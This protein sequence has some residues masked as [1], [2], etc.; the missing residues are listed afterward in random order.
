MSAKQ[1]A[2]EAYDQSKK[3][4][5][6]GF[7]SWWKRENTSDTLKGTRSM[8][9]LLVF[10]IFQMISVNFVGTVFVVIMLRVVPES[11]RGKL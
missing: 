10:C 1:I 7:V 3:W 4:S 8:S 2:K 6:I 11:H 9:L 5:Q